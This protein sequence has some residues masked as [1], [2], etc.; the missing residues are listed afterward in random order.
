MSSDENTPI[1]RGRGRPPKAIPALTPELEKLLTAEDVAELEKAAHD[2][3]TEERKADARQA[4]LKEA[5]EKARQDL[6]PGAELLDIQID[7]P[8]HSDR[9]TIDQVSYMHG[10]TYKVPKVKYDTL[11][12]IMARAWQHENEI[13]GANSNAYRKPRGVMLRPDTHGNVMR[14]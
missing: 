10:G 6:I 8:G 3:V 14:I 5:M 12:D 2:A 4:F 1:K 9:I 11:V 7:L 13:G